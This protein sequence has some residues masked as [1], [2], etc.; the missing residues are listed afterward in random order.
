MIAVGDGGGE[1]LEQH[2]KRAN[3]GEW[4]FAKARGTARQLHGTEIDLGRH[5]APQWSVERGISASMR[6]AEK[7]AANGGAFIPRWDPPVERHRVHRTQP[8]A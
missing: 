7:A 8:A 4:W 1:L 2:R 3:R 5:K 6:K